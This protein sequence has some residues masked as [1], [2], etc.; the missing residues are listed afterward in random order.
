ML[1][2]GA[3]MIP[4]TTYAE[5]APKKAKTEKSENGSKKRKKNKKNAAKNQT[6]QETAKPKSKKHPYDTFMKNVVST[7]SGDFGKLYKTNKDKIFLEMPV[8]NMGRRLLVG[9]TVSEV[10]HPATVGIGYRFVK[11][12]CLQIDKRDSIIVMTKPNDG[13]SSMDPA[14]DKA[15]KLS[16]T[17]QMYKRVSMTAYTKDSS[18]VIF[19]ITSLLKEFQP[20]NRE[21]SVSKDGDSKTTYFADMK[22]F[23]D[24]AS[25]KM[26]NN[27]D[28]SKTV[29]IFKVKVGEVSVG[30]TI[31][32]LLLPQETMK[33]RIQDI[34]VGVFST[35]GINGQPKY[36]V[37]TEADGFKTYRLANRWRI[38]P[39]DEEAWL[40]GNTVTVKKPILWYVDNSFPEAWVPSIKAGILRWNAA[41]EK[42]GLKDVMQVRMFP[43]AEED[44]E[45][46]P[47]NVKY[48]CIR[49]VPNIT[50]NAMGPS[51]VD[52][53]SGEILCASVFI[54]NDVVRLINHWRFIQTA[55]VDPRVRTSKMPADVLDE[56]LR[57]VVAHEVGHTLGMM[58]NMSA[59]ASIPVDSLRNANFTAR[60]GTTTSIMDY[61][62]FNYVAQPGDKDVKL[63]PPDLGVY[64]YYLIDWL[65][66]PVPQAKNMWEEAE[67]AS[68][69]IDAVRGNKMYRYG[70]QQIT[71][72][73]DPSCL[74]EDLGDDPIK[75][76]NY[77]VSNLKYI[78]PNIN[79]WLS[80]DTD[81]TLRASIYKRFVNQYYGYINNVL[82]Q[83]GGVYLNNYWQGADQPTV[84][85]LDK[86]VQKQSLAWVVKQLREIS[87]IDNSDL[88]SHF[89]YSVP[90]SNKLCSVIAGRLASTIPEHV[91]LSSS[92]AGNKAYGMD[93]YYNDL[94]NEVFA[95]SIA[96]K[97]LTSGEKTLQRE[98]VKA[99]ATPV[100]QLGKAQKSLM[101]FEDDE[102]EDCELGNA[103]EPY[104]DKINVS[105][106]SE[107]DG[108]NAVM[109][110]KVMK[111]AA[112]MKQAAPASD[113]AHYENLYRTAKNSL[114]K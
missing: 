39:S 64:D 43:S 63:T 90:V 48:T 50:M 95:S 19:E 61:A 52:P 65:Y 103:N 93:G 58:H 53:A 49:Y 2:A 73:Y 83:V 101:L 91:T 60:Y 23:A 35:S 37:S 105:A 85:P 13:A 26:Y 68:K 94:Y 29:S 51:W 84:T 112:S 41:F 57:Y 46:D 47:D 25:V 67:I 10:S 70:A 11:P 75:A 106:I 88:T 110:D 89:A 66:R 78:M 113:R 77:G 114:D 71:D 17:P 99:I 28:I 55:Q 16:F 7:A 59:S 24:N 81:W 104:Q 109:L 18:A 36:N 30:T 1:L 31:S 62:R 74:S 80:D 33:P 4:C 38:E 92:Y 108:Y 111:M 76:G 32:M 12:I 6:A 34:R 86:K 9:G 21:V 8:K 3:M 54:Y 40:A 69:T 97:R 45:F 100:N 87:W 98:L 42:L 79:V 72:Y 96:G 107:A 20:K 22:V 82:W 44:P 56:S 15:M 102:A 27:V 14:M 5:A